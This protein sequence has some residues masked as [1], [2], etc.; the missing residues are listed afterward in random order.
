MIAAGMDP[1]RQA[2]QVQPDKAP[3]RNLYAEGPIAFVGQQVLKRMADKGWPCRIFEHWRT[4]ERQ[5][6]MI[7][8]GA[9]KAGPWQ[10]AHQYGLAVDVIHAR[11]AWDVPERFWTDLAAVVKVIEECYKV[12]LEHGHTWRFRDSAHIE[13]KNFRKYRD[14]WGHRRPTEAELDACF[15]AEMPGV[16]KA[17]LRTPQGRKRLRSLD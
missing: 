4:P 13:L 8:K 17:Y 10:S 16:W 9:S 1:R 6:Q 14:A 11:H 7:A 5:A 15:A 2:V 3:F 12:D